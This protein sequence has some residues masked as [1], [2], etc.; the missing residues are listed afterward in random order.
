[1]EYT[2]EKDISIVEIDYTETI[3]IKITDEKTVTIELIKD[4]YI[5]NTIREFMILISK[6]KDVFTGSNDN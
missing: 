2:V 4:A 5:D 3:K 6:L 1:M